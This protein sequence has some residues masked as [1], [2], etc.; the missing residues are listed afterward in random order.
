MGNKKSN[1]KK[2]SL[3]QIPD[4]VKLYFTQLCIAVT[5][6]FLNKLFFKE[7]VSEIIQKV[8]EDFSPIVIYT[9]PWYQIL[10]KSFLIIVIIYAL[11]FVISKLTNPVVGKVLYISLSLAVALA[12][13]TSFAGGILT[14]N[15]GNGVFQFLTSQIEWFGGALIISG[16]ENGKVLFKKIML[17]ISLVFLS[18]VLGALIF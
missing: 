9:Q 13:G 16:I 10:I 6:W 11:I 4:F 2:F 1:Q 12:A 15:W 7:A 18:V 14:H 17:G 5:V 8:S 3:Q